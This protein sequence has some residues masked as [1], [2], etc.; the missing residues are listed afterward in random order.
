MLK[1]FKFKNAYSFLG[2]T[3]L[4]MEANYGMKDHVDFIRDV[5]KDGMNE[6]LLPVAAIFGAN[7]GGKSNVIQ[8]L[9]DCAMNICGRSTSVE[10]DSFFPGRSLKNRTFALAKKPAS[11][12]EHELTLVLKGNEYSYRYVSTGREVISES[13]DHKQ[14][15][16]NGKPNNILTRDT[17]KNHFVLNIDHIDNS[18]IKR[19]ICD[20]SQKRKDILIANMMGSIGIEPF[21]SISNWCGSVLFVTQISSEGERTNSLSR[22][23]AWAEEDASHKKR[24]SE[25]ISKFDEAIRYV[26]VKVSDDQILLET[27]KKA[28]KSKTR[29]KQFQLQ[30]AHNARENASALFPIHWESAGTRKLLEL[31]LPLFNALEFGRPLVYDE[32]DVMLHPLVFLRLVAMFNDPEDNPYNAQLVFA[33]HDTVVMTREHLRRDEIHIV[34]K[35]EFGESTICR[36]SD[37]EDQ[38]GK[39]IRKDAQYN[40]LYFDGILGP[41]HDSFFEA[42]V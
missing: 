35:N 19:F 24:L 21:A 4:S 2:E 13:L 25:F 11:S 27:D 3:E 29:T 23:A 22:L 31:F 15:G 42:K 38:G 28:S 37:Y 5:G 16:S 10:L 18:D 39:K 17:E 8:A 36:F 14:A 9:L 33:A 34:D 41:V 20:L 40:K 1:R 12:F 26:D 6:Y 32:L 7:A 30:L